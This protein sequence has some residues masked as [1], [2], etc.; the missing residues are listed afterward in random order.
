MNPVVPAERDIRAEE[1]VIDADKIKGT[2]Q[3]RGVI[4][5]RGITMISTQKRI[6]ASVAGIHR[7]IISEC[8][9]FAYENMRGQRQYCAYNF[10]A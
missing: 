8:L 2:S 1:K 6:P 10:H 4:E 7:S 9:N 5:K 3:R